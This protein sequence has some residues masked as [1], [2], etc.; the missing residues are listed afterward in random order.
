MTLAERFDVASS[1][2]IEANMA[3]ASLTSPILITIE[4]K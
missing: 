2:R 3:V 1:R 4:G